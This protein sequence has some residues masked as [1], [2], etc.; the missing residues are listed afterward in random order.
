MRVGASVFRR[1]RRGKAA[2]RYTV[3]IRCP[4]GRVIERVGFTDKAASQQLAAQL[5]RE[6]ERREMGLHD[7]FEGARKCSL[8]THLEQFL[9]AMQNGTLSRR[10]RGG[11][12]TDDYIVRSRKRLLAMFTWLGA[13]RVEHLDQAEAERML[14]DQVGAGWSDKTRDDHAALL[15]QFGGWLMQDGRWERNPF[16]RLRPVRDQASR[17]FTRHALTVHELGRLIEAAEVRALQEY[18]NSNPTAKPDTLER[19]RL[20]GWERGVLYQVAAYTGLRRG[21]VT[22]LVWGDLQLGPEPA[23]QVRAETA[24]NRRG[25]RLEVPRWLGVRLEEVR[26]RRAVATGTPP[27]ARSRVFG[28]SYRHVTERLKQDAV[29]AGIGTVQARGRVADDHGHVIDLHSLRGTLATL[30]AEVGMPARLLQQ[31][32]RHSDI[33]LTMEVYAKVREVSM[34]EQV[35]RLPQPVPV[36]VENLPTPAYAGRPQPTTKDRTGTGS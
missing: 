16:D 20:A 27:A 15:R 10:R 3:Q 17:T 8:A 6:I 14:L 1:R 29:W 7:R 11:R 28:A 26:A 30:A 35:E 13:S 33:R 9:V 21:E 22:A 5:V 2:R 4:D 18:R 25:A 34:R 19:K 12:P 36:P 24:K 23:I 31:H 32:M